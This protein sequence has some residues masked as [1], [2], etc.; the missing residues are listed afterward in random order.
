M[1]KAKVKYTENGR[2]NI[3]N[4]RKKLLFQRRQVPVASAT[5]T[6]PCLEVFA[7]SKDKLP[8]GKQRGVRGENHVRVKKSLV[9]NQQGGGI[10]SDL[11]FL[12]E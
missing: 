2:E 11:A 1:D 7:L 4:R 6:H 5:S 10:S 3:F 12:I 9:I 8:G